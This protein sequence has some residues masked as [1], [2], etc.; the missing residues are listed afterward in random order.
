MKVKSKC[1]WMIG[2]I[3]VRNS[4]RNRY[5]K[6]MFCQQIDIVWFISKVICEGNYKSLGFVQKMARKNARHHA[7]QY[8]LRRAKRD[9]VGAL[10]HRFAF[11]GPE[12]LHRAALLPMVGAMVSA[13]D[14]IWF[15]PP[16]FDVNNFF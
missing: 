9:Y 8:C 16:A 4:S 12:V 5:D 15:D 11:I 13:L 7:C 1:F 3:S 14:P 6:K 10:P 2:I